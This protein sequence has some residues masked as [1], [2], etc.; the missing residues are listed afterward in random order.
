AQGPV[1]AGFRRRRELDGLPRAAGDGA[2]PGRVDRLLAP[3]AAGGA[4]ALELALIH[5]TAAEARGRCKQ[6]L[7]SRPRARQAPRKYGPTDERRRQILAAAGE[8]FA[9]RG[10]AGT[11]TRQIAAAVGTTETVLFRHF[12]TKESLYAAILEDRVPAAAVERWLKQLKTLA[13]RR[14][15][16]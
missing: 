4:R 2:N 7:P 16:E 12:P 9:G 3:G 6:G 1:A 14:D 8:L 11:T 10:F 15:D 5:S 13:D